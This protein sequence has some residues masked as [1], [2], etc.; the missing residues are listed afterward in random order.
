MN[1]NQPIEPVRRQIMERTGSPKRTNSKSPVRLP[2]KEIK[3]T[4]CQRTTM[5]ANVTFSHDGSQSNSVTIAAPRVA[6]PAGVKKTNTIGA[7]GNTK[8]HLNRAPPSGGNGNDSDSTAEDRNRAARK[9]PQKK[10]ATPQV[11]KGQ[12]FS[13]GPRVNLGLDELKSFSNP[14]KARQSPD[15]GAFGSYAGD[16]NSGDSDSEGEFSEGS[17]SQVS[18]SGESDDRS[19]GGETDDMTADGEYSGSPQG[20]YMDAN[21]GQSDMPSKQMTSSERRQLKYD[22]LSKIQA[23]ERK[24]V[25]VSKKFTSKHKLVHIQAEYNRLSTIL[26]NEAGVKFGRKLLMGAVGVTEWLN[27]RF[28]PV[29][30]K[31]EGWSESVM[32]NIEDFDHSLERIVAKWTSHVEVA[33][34][35]ELMTALAG[36]AFMFHM[37][38]SILSNPASILGAMGSQKPDMMEN[39][40]KK[41]MGGAMGGGGKNALDTGDDDDSDDDGMS[42]PSMNLN[43]LSS[44]QQGG[45]ATRGTGAYRKPKDG[46]SSD[47]DGSEYS[48]GSSGSETDASSASS[49]EEKPRARMVSIPRVK[50][51]KGRKK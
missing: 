4:S 35:M 33:P 27:T 14:T 13:A 10:P 38:K 51:P 30:A 6:A 29:G 50:G 18:S 7:S 5:P 46:D 24:G 34:E 39:M 48:E 31:L 44:Q 42:P 8:I 17:A 36:S 3:M 28:D 19:A 40:L 45:V 49:E 25:Q 12:P 2:P 26:A 1:I 47:S 23:L 21:M 11:L 43:P 32:E 22:L 9:V 15:G 20:Q 37:S 16:N 41:M